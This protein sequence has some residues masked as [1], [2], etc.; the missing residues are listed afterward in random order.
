VNWQIEFIKKA[1]KEFLCLDKQTRSRIIKFLE[2]NLVKHNNPRSLGKALH[3]NLAG[4]WRYRVG[5]CRI[6]CQIQDHHLLIL[7]VAIGHRKD[8][9]KIN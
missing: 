8:V 7:V 5:D 2:D 3:G 4:L 6:I 1:K 9:Y